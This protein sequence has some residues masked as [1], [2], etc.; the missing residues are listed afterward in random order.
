VV[1]DLQELW[2]C[3]S[4]QLSLRSG[5]IVDELLIERRYN[6]AVNGCEYAEGFILESSLKID[7]DDLFRI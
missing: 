7:V 1:I 6:G 2:K 3:Y 5:K 4:T